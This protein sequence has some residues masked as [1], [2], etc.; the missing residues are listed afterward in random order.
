[1]VSGG[2]KKWILYMKMRLIYKIIENP[3]PKYMFNFLF[4]PSD[5]HS[6]F[7]SDSTTDFIP[8]CF[9]SLLGKDTFLC[10][11]AV[12]CGIISPQS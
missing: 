7:T 5:T 8:F 11:A 6:N 9:K 4:W 2:K 3:V 10:S 1:M 12:L